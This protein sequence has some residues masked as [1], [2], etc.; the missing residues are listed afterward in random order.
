MSNY[1][2]YFGDLVSKAD[3]KNEID[4]GVHLNHKY[5]RAR[6]NFMYTHPNQLRTMTTHHSKKISHSKQNDLLG[7]IEMLAYKPP[8]ILPISE[9]TKQINIKKK[10]PFD[11][12]ETE[13]GSKPPTEKPAVK[14][15]VP[16]QRVVNGG[17]KEPVVKPEPRIQPKPP[18]K[19]VVVKNDDL[20]KQLVDKG[21]AKVHYKKD[22]PKPKP[23]PTP[24][25]YGGKTAKEIGAMSQQDYYTFN[26]NMATK[27][28]K[29]GKDWRPPV[30]QGW[31]PAVERPYQG[32]I[33]TLPSTNAPH[34]MRRPL[35]PAKPVVVKPPPKKVV[36]VS[37]KPNPN[38]KPPIRHCI[39]DCP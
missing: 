9:Y 36:E 21:L 15:A 30:K 24:T 26:K 27:M 25:L 4:F 7:A 32:K 2:D 13:K 38:I 20:L 3:T 33:Q 6:R 17:A 23:T 29:E 1:S 19:P 14:P 37:I 31:K 35:E 18:K 11:I 10:K 12:S 28:Y 22:Q 8:E 34:N 5:D 16:T 39:G